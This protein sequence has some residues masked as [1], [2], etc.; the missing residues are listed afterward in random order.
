VLFVAGNTTSM[1]HRDWAMK[2]QEAS[3]I[4]R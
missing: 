2:S 3:R 4:D 1:S